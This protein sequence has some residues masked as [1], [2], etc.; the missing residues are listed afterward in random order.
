MWN[1]LRWWEHTTRIGRRA[2]HE[3]ARC[4]SHVAFTGRERR[5]AH[6]FSLADFPLICHAHLQ[7]TWRRMRADDTMLAIGSQTCA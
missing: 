2:W 4:A 5:C 6:G 7:W 1:D 3:R